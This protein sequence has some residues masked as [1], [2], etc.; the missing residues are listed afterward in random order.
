MY[1]CITKLCT[2]LLTDVAQS[3]EAEDVMQIVSC[4]FLKINSYRGEM[5]FGSWLKRIVE[6][7][8][9]V[10]PRRKIKFE[11]INRRFRRR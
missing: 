2:I 5:S 11:E 10:L 8:I 1:D 6:Q 4:S 3:V 7:T 9:D